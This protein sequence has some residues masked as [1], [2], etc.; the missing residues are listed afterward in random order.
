MPEPH[1]DDQ[2]DLGNPTLQRFFQGLVRRPIAVLMACLALAG[3]SL[4]AAGRIPVELIPS[5]FGSSSVTVNAPWV[6]ANPG[7]I[8]QRVILPL[9]DELRTLPGVQD[10]LAVA[11]A[12]SATVV[13]NFPGN[14]D[15]EQAHA[16]VSDRIERVRPLLPREVDRITIRRWNSGDMPIMWMGVRYPVT[17]RERSQEILAEVLQPRIEAIEGVASARVNGI[18]PSSVRILLDEDRVAANRVD[19]G[20]LVRQLQADNIA[21]PLGDLDAAGSRFLI[22]MDARFESLE[23]IEN[24]VVRP[25][26][27]LK[28]IGRVAKVRSAPEHFFR[29]D[30]D[31]TLGVAISKETSANTFEVCKRIQKVVE[32]EFANDA[33][34]G[35]FEYSIFWNEGDNIREI[36]TNLVRDAAL[37][38]LIASL[39]LFAFLRRVGLTLLISVSIPFSVLVTLTWIWASGE[40]FNLF[41][42]TGIAIAIGM[43]VDNAVVIVESIFTRLMRK[44]SLEDACTKGPSEVMLAVTTATLTTVV[45]FLPLIFMSEERNTRLVSSA[46]GIPLCISLIGALIL[47]IFIVP[48]FSRN[49]MKEDSMQELAIRMREREKRGGGLLSKLQNFFTRLVGW[50]LDHRFRAFTLAGLFLASGAFARAGNSFSGGEMMG[51]S[52]LSI[53]FSLSEGTT[54]YDADQAIAELEKTILAKPFKEAIDDPVIGIQYD[55][56]GGTV[57]MWH[58]SKPSPDE[59]KV[60]REYFKENAPATAI[61]DFQFE[62]SFD[63][64]NSTDEHWVR[65]QLSGPDSLSVEQYAASLREIARADSAI[66]EVADPARTTREMRVSLDR[67]R[68]SRLGIS[69]QAVLGTIEWGL[70]GFMVSRFETERSDIPLIL[71]FDDPDVPDRERLKEMMLMLPTGG[72]VPLDTIAD[73]K[74]ARAPASISRRNGLTSAI[75]GLLPFNEDIRERRVLLEQLTEQLELPEGYSWKQVG[76]WSGFSQDMGEM[77]TAFTLSIALVFLLMGLLFNSLVLPLSVL[78]TIWF[79]VTGANWAFKLTGTPMDLMGMVGMIVL[80]GVVVNNGIVL[81]DRILQ[82]EASGLPRRD[83][84]LQATRDRLRPVLMTALTTIFG[85]LPIALSEE[86]GMGFSFKGLAIGVAG[87]LAFTTFFTLWIVPLL[88]ATFNDF[89]AL[90]ARRFNKA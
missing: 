9:E 17:D 77:K 7:E 33:Q 62:R 61:F 2:R 24:F 35:R 75:V 50:S 22:R 59:E 26:L 63:E 10:I 23:E 81:V 44:E 78:S 25:G 42:M 20:A 68:M 36:L 18:P 3:M 4:I 80:A 14:Y 64:R 88:Y 28:D 27:K 65:V 8:E 15:M 46:M 11:S 19:I 51:G 49:V 16:E 54:L 56:S 79:A 39:V 12:G 60:I 53:K 30:G 21:S 76:G 90:V 41:T 5:G 85:L 58:D 71:E 57:N 45:V 48:V 43:L 66:K 67:D 82:H 74:S 55:R 13:L 34:L 6:G 84:I 32:N 38:G 69:S 52:Q 40:S 87:G 31:Y 86:T 83:A 37:G 70:R 47:A 89:G 1:P 29:V 72:V 73:F